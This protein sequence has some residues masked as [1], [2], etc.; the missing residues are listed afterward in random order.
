M[1]EVTRIRV[2]GL[3]KW[4]QNLIERLDADLTAVEARVAATAG[5]VTTETD[6]IWDPFSDNP[7]ALPERT[8]VCFKL[9]RDRRDGGI[10]VNI[11][12]DHSGERVLSV[13]G[14][15]RIHIE[16]RASNLIHIYL[17]N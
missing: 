12:E 17:K 13:S 2:K 6:V 3:P 7:H 10:D 15:R 14:A 1:R 4:A 9:N 8:A 11:T 5:P 16:P